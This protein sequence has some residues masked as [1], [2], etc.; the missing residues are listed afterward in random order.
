MFL[1]YLS[2]A[3]SGLRIL[4]WKIILWVFPVAWVSKKSYSACSLGT[5]LF[6]IYAIVM[7]ELALLASLL[8]KYE[9]CAILLLRFDLLVKKSYVFFWIISLCA[10]RLFFN[11]SRFLPSVS[12]FLANIKQKSKY[13]WC[14]FWWFQNLVLVIERR[15]SE[16]SRIREKY[17]DRIPVWSLLSQEILGIKSH[18]LLF[19][20]SLWHSCFLF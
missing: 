12:P 20:A 10:R 3:I 2:M 16:S 7:L 5:S 19:V 17:P 18:V 6:Y 15:Q 1:F 14:K 4:G 13:L 8:Y 11:F 9:K